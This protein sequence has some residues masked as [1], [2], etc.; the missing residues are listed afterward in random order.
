MKDVIERT[1]SDISR[2]WLPDDAMMLGVLL[3][4]TADEALP[5]AVDDV[6]SCEAADTDVLLGPAPLAGHGWPI[7]RASE[8]EEPL[9]TKLAWLASKLETESALLEGLA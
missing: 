9:T 8:L 5:S 4:E 1:M 2:T 3:V 7:E 6:A